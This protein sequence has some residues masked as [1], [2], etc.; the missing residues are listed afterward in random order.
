MRI[1]CYLKIVFFTQ[2]QLVKRLYANIDTP[3]ITVSPIPAIAV[4]LNCEMGR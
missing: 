3:A 4:Q 2:Y 1:R